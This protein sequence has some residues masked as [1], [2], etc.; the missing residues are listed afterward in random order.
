M[1]TRE[2]EK[3]AAIL[4]ACLVIAVLITGFILWLRYR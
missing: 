3:T 4:V 1:S 2:K